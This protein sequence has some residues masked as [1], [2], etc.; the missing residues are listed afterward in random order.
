MIFIVTDQRHRYTHDSVVAVLGGSV[1]VLDYDTLFASKTLARGTY[2]MTDADRLGRADHERASLTYRL[3]RKNGQTV[4]NDPARQ[5]G[6]Y[7]LL[8][9]LHREGINSFNAYRAE[10]FDRPERWPVFVRTEGD[11]SRPLSGLI[12][13]Q[14]ILDEF[15]E[16][17][18]DGGIPLTSL[19]IIEYRAE[20][21]APG[22]YRKL[23]VFRV[24]D[25]MIGYTCVHD[26]N[27]LV[28]YGRPG[29]ATMELYEDE[30]RLVRD[31]PYGEQMRSVFDLANIEYGRVDFGLVGGRAEIY[32]INTNPDISLS[33][34]SNGVA[35]RDESN[36]L[37]RENYLAAMRA[38]SAV[39]GSGLA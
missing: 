15:I 12:G 19:L 6:R 24:A 38:L 22:L 2:I 7:G 17:L 20:E 36:A 5:L 23:S 30:L 28:K 29:I 37:F 31:N 35:M 34:K 33:P 13:N 39:A 1:T 25:R 21:V 18:V 27:W 11:H 14:A 32:E 26:R 3:L 9:K 16:T 8:R 10:S 4:L